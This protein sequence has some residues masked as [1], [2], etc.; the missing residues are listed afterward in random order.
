[1]FEKLLNLRDETLITVISILV[2]SLFLLILIKKGKIRHDT[3][4]IVYAGIAIALAFVLSSIRIFRMPQGGS[5]TP[6]SMLPLFIFAFMFGPVPGMIAGALYGFLQLLQDAYVVHWA[7]L[8]LDYPLAFAAIG[9]AGFFKNNRIAGIITGSAARFA[10][11]FVSGFIFFASYAPE[12]QDPVLY[13][14][15]YNS[16]MAVETTITVILAIPVLA[17]LRRQL[18]ITGR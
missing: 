7:Q 14:L 10:F 15:I 5:I 11:H 3:R 6:G 8:L 4:L 16:F 18:K 2:V 9:L 1:M 17:A 12:G 13:S